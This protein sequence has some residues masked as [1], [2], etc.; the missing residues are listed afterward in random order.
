MYEQLE[1]W[2]GVCEKLG[3]DPKILPDVSMLPE[4]SASFTLNSFKAK[5]IADAYNQVDL[6]NGI[7]GNDYYRPWFYR[8]LGGGF[9]FVY[10]NWVTYGDLRHAAAGLCFLSE[11]GAESA[12][13]SH[14]NVYE[15]LD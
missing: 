12:A 2:E 4:K 5:M 11:N 1:S 7:N 3:H 13:N 14:I 9:S 10:V 6:E 8:K 15:A